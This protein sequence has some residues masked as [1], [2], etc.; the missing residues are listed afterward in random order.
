VAH[1]SFG[2]IA[3]ELLNQQS[4]IVKRLDAEFRPILPR[5]LWLGCRDRQQKACPV[6]ML[7]LVGDRH[8]TAAVN[9]ADDAEGATEQRMRW[10]AHGH[11]DGG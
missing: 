8:V 6:A 1:R 4:Q 10:V 9:G 2:S 5:R 3:I 11:F 7:D